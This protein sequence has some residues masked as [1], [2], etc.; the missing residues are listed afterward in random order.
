MAS[1]LKHENSIVTDKFVVYKYLW[2]KMPSVD[3]C[4]TFHSI[5]CG[6]GTK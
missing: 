1:L 2:G 3:Q 4:T 6:Y 5:K